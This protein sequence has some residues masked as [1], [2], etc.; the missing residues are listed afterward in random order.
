MKKHLKKF[1]HQPKKVTIVSLIIAIIIGTFGYI[2]IHKIPK[3]LFVENNNSEIKNI[4]LSFSSAGK[5]K[6][7]LIK[8]GDKV[9]KGQ[10]LAT[11]SADNADGSFLQAQAV[12]EAAKANYQKII[13]GA[14]GNAIDVARSAVNT[15][16]V[17]LEQITNQQN[18]LVTN[19]L[20]K[21]YSDNLV[22]YPDSDKITNSPVITGNYNGL[23]EGDYFV[24]FKD[25]NYISIKYLGLES[26]TTEFNTLPR[27]LGVNGLLISFPLGQNGYLLNNSW[28]IHIPNKSGLNY[29]NN[30]NAYQLALQTKEQVIAAAQAALDQANSSLQLVVANAR[31][32]DVA[33]AQAQIENAYGVLISN[34]AYNNTIII[35]PYDGVINEIH[36]V[37]GQTVSQNE[38][39]IN[40][41]KSSN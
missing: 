11:L 1:V 36:V 2:S 39:I 13:N 20:R 34:P 18:T 23:K 16:R 26:G 9:K 15:A 40:F 37:F 24:S 27:P 41:L 12:Y 14:T 19:A 35:A 10:I 29:T 21:L 4:E 6:N 8:K 3:D 30:L 25:I 22:A 38:P 31:P 28:T 5:I 7:I 33:A 32:E 17:N